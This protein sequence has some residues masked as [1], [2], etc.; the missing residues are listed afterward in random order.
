MSLLVNDIVWW[1]LSLESII[2]SWIPGIA[3]FCLG[4]W[5]ARIDDRRKLKQKLKDDLLQIFIPI[6]NSGQTITMPEAEGAARRMLHTFN[7]YKRIYPGTFDKAAEEK[8]GTILADGFIAHGKVNQA[9]M[10][11]N[12]VQDLIKNL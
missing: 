11:P 1:K 10:E 6:F 9:F 2:N 7:A 3:T 4:V 8:L 12:T 5:F